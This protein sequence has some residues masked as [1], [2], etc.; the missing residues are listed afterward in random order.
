MN[1][2]FKRCDQCKAKPATIKCYD[3]Q[4]DQPTRLCYNCDLNHHAILDHNKQIIPYTQME[5]E[6]SSPNTPLKENTPPSEPTSEL[7]KKLKALQN[8][9]SIKLKSSQITEY[10]SQTDDNFHKSLRQQ[11]IKAIDLR[12]KIKFQE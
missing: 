3:C 9:S 6:T 4:P 2:Q 7:K 1:K 11:E 8:A 12:Y 5:E 10:E